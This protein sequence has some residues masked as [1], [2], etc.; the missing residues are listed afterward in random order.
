MSSVRQIASRTGVSPTTVSRVLNQHPDV[1]AV[2]RRKV[3]QAMNQSGYAHATPVRQACSVGLVS[4]GIRKK[5]SI[6]DSFLL[7]GIRAGLED[8]DLDIQV[9]NLG[10]E[11]TKE[12]TYTDYFTKR[13]I[14]GVFLQTDEH[15]Q[16]IRDAIVAERFPCVLLAD[17]TDD[18]GVS[19]VCCD[20]RP[21]SRE[22]VEHLIH[23]GHRRIAIAILRQSD[24]DHQD[25]FSGY[26]DALE[27][28]GLEVDDALVRYIPPTPQAGANVINT[29][30]SRPEPPTAVF[31][32]DPFSASG[33]LCRAHE[34]GLSIPE[35][36][37]IIGM[38]DG[39]ARRQ[40]FPRLTAVCQPTEDIGFEAARW[41]G[42]VIRG[43]A[44]ADPCRVHLRAT[45]EINR[46]TAIP[47]ATLVRFQPD[48]TPLT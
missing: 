5:I 44:E 47:P 37:S 17:R 21:A 34:I 36:L 35:Q 33:A 6:Y 20:S 24:R 48:G 27:A 22:A 28:H 42:G 45:L 39:D 25:R 46:T 23:L 10:L 13:G 12:Q 7:N 38:D 2:T 3:L 31:F 4:T 32:T 19:Y 16:S 30:M 11:H 8:R 26:K 14:A 41:L 15:G 40:V 18:P 1:S 9:M 29:L 43:T